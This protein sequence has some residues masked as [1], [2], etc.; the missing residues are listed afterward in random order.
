MTRF[1]AATDDG[2][3]ELFADAIR[4]HRERESAF[5]TIEASEDSNEADDS[6]DTVPWVQFSD[7]IVN[8]DCTDD[9]LTRLKSL[10][11]SFSA[12]IIEDLTSPED[13]DGTNVR[14][15]VRADDERI[16]AFVER[17]FREVYERP[18]EY[19]AWVTAV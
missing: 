16:A 7:D 10:L 13:T 12:F 5:L 18:A 4:A 2:R 1:D 3:S 19:R 14:V 11:D 15:S 17:I 8:L 6:E 9:E